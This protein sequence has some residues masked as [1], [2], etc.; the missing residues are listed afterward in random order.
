MVR[1]HS[2]CD[3]GTVRLK[4]RRIDK[5]HRR[6]EVGEPRSQV[7]YLL[8]ARGRRLS[9]SSWSFSNSVFIR[10]GKTI[11]DVFFFFFCKKI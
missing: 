6:F 4:E 9:T 7:G 8:Q 1:S 3:G 5:V 11:I 10:S 2:W